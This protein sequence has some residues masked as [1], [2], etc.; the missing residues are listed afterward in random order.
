[1]LVEKN[2]PPAEVHYDEIEYL[3][4]IISGSS[5]THDNRLKIFQRRH[6]GLLSF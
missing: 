1:M 5:L 4:L 6:F 3:S 2:R